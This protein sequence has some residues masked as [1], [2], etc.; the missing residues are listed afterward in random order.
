MAWQHIEATLR[1]EQTQTRWCPGPVTDTEQQSAHAGT[2]GDETDMH[3]R[4]GGGRDGHAGNRP[5]DQY[6]A[7]SEKGEESGESGEP[8]G[9]L[10]CDDHCTQPADCEWGSMLQA[11]RIQRVRWLH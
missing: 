3:L 4:D 6:A 8:G 5:Y 7:L 11:S 1:Q 9:T 2:G 10:A